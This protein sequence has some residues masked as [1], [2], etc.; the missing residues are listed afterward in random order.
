MDFQY[1]FDYQ[2]AFTNAG[3]NSDYTM[4]MPPG[5]EFFQEP[6]MNTEDFQ[7]LDMIANLMSKDPLLYANK[8]MLGG[9]G[10]ADV[11]QQRAQQNMLNQMAIGIN[12]GNNGGPSGGHQLGRNET[13]G[14]LQ[15]HEQNSPQIVMNG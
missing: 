9:V 14:Q 7:E 2:W 8:K 6:K 12:V 4:F 1:D 11:E 10:G 5:F 15:V 3:Y 13:N